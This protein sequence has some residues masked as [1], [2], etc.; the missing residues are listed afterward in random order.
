MVR[1]ADE[2]GKNPVILLY[3]YFR[4]LTALYSGKNQ[5]EN[6]TFLISHNT[7]HLSSV[8]RS[9]GEMFLSAAPPFQDILV[10]KGWNISEGR[11]PAMDPQAGSLGINLG[12]SGKNAWQVLSS[13]CQQT[14]TF[15]FNNTFT[16]IMQA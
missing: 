5:E 2:N 14:I 4:Q 12:V 1:S 9:G 15:P 3:F 7:T 13:T 8:A 16:L 11:L 10:M 6:K